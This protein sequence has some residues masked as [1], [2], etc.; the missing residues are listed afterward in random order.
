[1]N[2]YDIIISSLWDKS[3]MSSLAN[4]LNDSSA[5]QH[6]KARKHLTCAQKPTSPR[7]DAIDSPIDTRFLRRNSSCARDKRWRLRWSRFFMSPLVDAK[8]VTKSTAVAAESSKHWPENSE[9]I[10]QSK[11]SLLL[12]NVGVA[13][14]SN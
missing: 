6:R 14:L 4:D 12:S 10:S 7:I 5:I 11:L 1:M 3:Y 9:E 13:K 2:L 8:L